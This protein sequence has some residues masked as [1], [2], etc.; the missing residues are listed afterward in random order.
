MKYDDYKQDDSKCSKK[1]FSSIFYDNGKRLEIQ[2][3]KIRDG[4]I[5]FVSLAFKDTL[6][7]QTN[8]KDDNKSR[9]GTKPSR[10]KATK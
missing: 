2:T 4:K 3:N 7:K 1:K 5:S 8:N 10:E 9:K 6:L